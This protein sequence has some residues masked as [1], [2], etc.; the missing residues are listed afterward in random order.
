[1]FPIFAFCGVVWS[2]KIGVLPISLS[3]YSWLPWHVFFLFGFSWNF[4]FLLMFFFPGPN[5]YMFAYIFP[6][7]SHHPPPPPPTPNHTI[8]TKPHILHALRR[9]TWA[10]SSLCWNF[11]GRTSWPKSQRPGRETKN[12]RMYGCCCGCWVNFRWP[13]RSYSHVGYCKGCKLGCLPSQVT[14]FSQKLVVVILRPG[15]NVCPPLQRH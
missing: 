15:F 1:M 10:N 4:H 2:V 5:Y 8:P 7:N 6:A 11:C 3:F 13:P 14:W 12:P 9:T